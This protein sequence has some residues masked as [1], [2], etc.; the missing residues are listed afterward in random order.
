VS[1][2]TD[3]YA[4]VYLWVA[5]H[6]EGR[7]T[8]E[9]RREL[10]AGLAGTVCEVGVGPG[11]TF[12]HYPSTV[13]RIIAI[14]PDGALREHA[15][16]AA[17]GCPIPVQV[18]HGVAD[19]LPVLDGACDAV[20]FSL[21]LCSV[22]DLAGALAE[23]RRVLRPG[24]EVRFYEHVRS[25]RRL[26][27]KAED[28]LTPAWSRLAGGCHPNREPVAAIRAAGFHHV[29]ARRLSFSPVRG[30]P[31]FAHVIGRAVAPGE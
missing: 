14:E 6:A 5:A 13:E 18:C 10:L 19:R 25:S 2:G 9:H 15:A 4:R 8:R 27:A 20:V 11:L 24:G 3:H 23:T 16:T 12:P 17:R 21:V 22:P 30:T 7:G 26:V 1:R 31:T 29:E 28:A